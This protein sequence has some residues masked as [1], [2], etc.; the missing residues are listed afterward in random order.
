MVTERALCLTSVVST[1]P[2]IVPLKLELKLKYFIPLSVTE[3]GEAAGIQPGA[4]GE[5]DCFN[6]NERLGQRIQIGQKKKM[7]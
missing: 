2:V 6:L 7:M 1:L 4:R 5:S 3:R